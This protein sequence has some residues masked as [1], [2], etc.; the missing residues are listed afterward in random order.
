MKFVMAV[1]FPRGH[2]TFK[3]IKDKFRTDLAGAKKAGAGGIAFVTNQELTLS[4]REQ[5]NRLAAPLVA[6]IYHLERITSILDQPDMADVRSQFLD[7]GEEAALIQLGGQGGQAPGAGGGGG[8]AFGTN[9]RGGEGGRGGDVRVV[10]GLASK[11]VGAGGGGEGV[12]GDQAIGGGGGDGGEQLIVTLDSNDLRNIDRFDF[13][14]G[15]GGQAGGPGED[16]IVNAIDKEGNVLASFV[17]KGGDAGVP[18]RPLR[19]A[20]TKTVAAELSVTSVIIAHSWRINQLGFFSVLDGGWA[21]V[22]PVS[23][24]F[25]IDLPIVVELETGALQPDTQIAVRLRILSPSGLQVLEVDRAVC[26]PEHAIRRTRFGAV[27]S[28]SGSE[29]GIWRVQVCAGEVVLREYG[30]LIKTPA[31]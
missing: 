25:R 20:L 10:Q 31:R 6:E 30:L 18:A 3:S 5:L 19:A 23:N 9:A 29:G 27:L 1:Y 11:P 7:I 15:E 2:Q 17:A 21:D 26:V 28:F 22:T 14:V 8:G 13:R 12:I 16:T 24:P 4:V